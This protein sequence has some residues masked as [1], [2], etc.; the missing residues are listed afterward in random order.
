MLKGPHEHSNPKASLFLF[1]ARPERYQT[2]PIFHGQITKMCVSVAGRKTRVCGISGGQT[3]RTSQNACAHSKPFFFTFLSGRLAVAVFKEECHRTDTNHVLFVATRAKHNT[4]CR[5]QT[6][7]HNN[8]RTEKHGCVTKLG[9]RWA[10]L[11]PSLPK[12]D[13]SAGW[14]VGILASVKKKSSQE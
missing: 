6:R 2:R 1:V 13:N 14:Y 8:E 11:G 10:K 5:G 9:P 7:Q 4:N 3:R 12:L